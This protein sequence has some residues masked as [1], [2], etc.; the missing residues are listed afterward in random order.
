MLVLI[1]QWASSH[2]KNLL[3]REE[4]LPNWLDKISVGQST[5]EESMLLS[6]VLTEKTSTLSC[7][8]IQ[9]SF[10][11]RRVVEKPILG[12]RHLLNIF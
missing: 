3:L 2:K 1:A 10:S 12:S 4:I 11:N 8:Q 6:E 5:E 9:Q 7:V